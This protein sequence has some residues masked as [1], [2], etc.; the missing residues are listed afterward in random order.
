MDEKET[1][2]IRYRYYNYGT[3]F[4]KNI[5]KGTKAYGNGG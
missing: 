4:T 5:E 1:C 3:E 2:A